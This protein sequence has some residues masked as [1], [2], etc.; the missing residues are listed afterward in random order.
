[1]T[2]GMAMLAP[3]L[4]AFVGGTLVGPAL[5]AAVAGAWV[6]GAAALTM[7]VAVGS[8]YIS[9]RFYHG[10][11][12]DSSELNAQHTAKYLVQELKKEAACVQHEGNCRADGKEWAHVVREQN[13]P[14]Q[15]QI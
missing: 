14:A 13:P 2:V 1:M 7:A 8:G 4:G 3:H 15:V 10:A 5:T 12:A 11:Y 6:I 9:T